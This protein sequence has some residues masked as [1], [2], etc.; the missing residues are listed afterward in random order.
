[1]WRGVQ[2]CLCL[3]V[4]GMLMVSTGP[5]RSMEIDQSVPTIA[6]TD[7]PRSTISADEKCLSLLK[8]VRYNDASSAMD[9]DRRSAGKATALGLIF[10][11]RFALG[12]KEV[13][14][15]AKGRDVTF[16]IRDAGGLDNGGSHA[17]AIA[18]YRRCKNE[19][20]L[21]GLNDWRWQR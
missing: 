12:P 21:R 8:A 11:V 17:L 1:M 7:T 13:M 19:Q 16:E 14:K 10:G 3:T 2:L 20:T 15:N 6:G 18:D 9:R 4:T 5:A